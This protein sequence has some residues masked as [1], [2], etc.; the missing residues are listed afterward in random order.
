MEVFAQNLTIPGPIPLSLFSAVVPIP[1]HVVS[2]PCFT[3]GLVQPGDVTRQSMLLPL[4]L[5]VDRITDLSHLFK[6]N[7]LPC[8]WLSKY[9]FAPLQ[10]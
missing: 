5:I 1:Q 4:V 3:V 10:V 9:S 2:I 7:N 6:G 8:L